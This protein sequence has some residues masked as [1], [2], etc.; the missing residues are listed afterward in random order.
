MALIF[1]SYTI[2]RV[3]EALSV[4]SNSF[5]RAEELKSVRTQNTFVVKLVINETVE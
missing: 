2:H 5:N 1:L 3:M 4:T